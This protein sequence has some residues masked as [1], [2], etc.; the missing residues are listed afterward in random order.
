MARNRMREVKVPQ[1]Q[2][3]E[4][5]ERVMDPLPVLLSSPREYHVVNLQQ[6]VT[7]I[8]W[9]RCCTAW[10]SAQ[11]AIPLLPLADSLERGQDCSVSC[12]HRPGSILSSQGW[13]H[14]EHQWL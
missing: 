6:V 14:S 2:K 5:R 4:H 8:S 1:A 3:I 12:L 11:D 9:H 7:S 10:F 13:T